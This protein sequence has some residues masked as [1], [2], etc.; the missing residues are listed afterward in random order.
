VKAETEVYK[1][2]LLSEDSKIRMEA[3]NQLAK[4][5]DTKQLKFLMNFLFENS[6][7]NGPSIAI[8][9]IGN[10]QNEFGKNVLVDVYGRAND[11]EQKLIIES[12]LKLG[13]FK[14]FFAGYQLHKNIQEQLWPL[15]SGLKSDKLKNILSLGQQE[16]K[17]KL[18]S[19]WKTTKHWR[20]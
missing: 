8:K 19:A 5:G 15:L 10:S 14:K 3:I 12:L 6:I 4:S 1:S 17:E 11:N 7:A 18:D 16:F 9:A 2:K 20:K 13:V